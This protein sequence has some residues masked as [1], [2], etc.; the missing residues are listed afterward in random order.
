M[1]NDIVRPSSTQQPNPG[2]TSSAAPQQPTQPIPR[3]PS[4]AL[5]NEPPKKQP[6]G[7]K[8]W[9]MWGIVG[10][11]AIIVAATSA[12]VLWY[13]QQLAPVA[14]G[15]SS[16]ENVSLQP[17]ADGKS[18]GDELERKSVIRSSL[19]FQWYLKLTGNAAKLQAGPYKLGPGQSV[20]DIV[21]IITS[22]KTETFDVTFLPGNTLE[23][24]KKALLDVGFSE[25]EVDTA[26]SKAYDHP[27][28]ASKPANANLEGYI[29]GETYQ[30]PADATAEQIVERSLDELYAAIKENN[31]VARYKKRGLSL[32]EGI[33]LASIIQREVVTDADMAQVAQVFLLRLK[34]D[35]PLGS[36]V[37]YQ[38]IA[39]KIGVARDP[40]LDSPYN[41]RRYGGLPPGPISSPGKDA[42][43]SVANPAKGNFLYFL[44]GDDDKT[45]FAKTNAGHE[46]NIKK[47]CQKKCLIL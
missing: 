19:A 9:F 2:P 30:F 22:G 46:E 32:Y 26:L 23:K 36:D 15:S 24:H 12:T 34:K 20:S 35:M 8:W 1:N 14:S 3:P 21:G 38:Y 45:Y 25:T 43:L 42:L 44:S 37:T 10:V 16:L 7:G 18:L 40:N 13:Q 27:A 28:L 47:H 6:K 41:T 39:D 4:P 33:T 29:Y 11:I 5:E 17:G 31:L